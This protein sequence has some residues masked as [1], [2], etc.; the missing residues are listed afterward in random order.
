MIQSTYSSTVKKI[1][2][3]QNNIFNFNQLSN[4]KLKVSL[5]ASFNS[6]GSEKNLKLIKLYNLVWYITNQKPLIKGVGFNYIKKKILKRI[7]FNI[8]LS[9]YNTTNFIKYIS[10]LYLHFFHIY[11]QNSIKFNITAN[12][13]VI[14]LD[15][16]QFFFRNYIRKNQK[17]HI[18]VTFSLDK[19][20]RSF[21]LIKYLSH[22]FLLKNYK[23]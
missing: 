10:Q 4:N 3:N 15:N 20:S 13:V 18:K 5:K 7:I 22:L 1:L 2:I 17:I 19:I 6:F 21:Y 9:N 14:Y 11:Y 16:P 8:N 23:N 12:S